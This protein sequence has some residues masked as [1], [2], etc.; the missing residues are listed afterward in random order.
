MIKNKFLVILSLIFIAFLG[1]FMSLNSK[2]DI[3]R[4]KSFIL[5]DNADFVSGGAISV[6]EN[7][8]VVTGSAIEIIPIDKDISDKYLKPFVTR[9]KERSYMNNYS[10][11]SHNHCADCYNGDLHVHDGESC[12]YEVR[13]KI[14]LGLAGNKIYRSNNAIDWTLVLSRNVS[15]LTYANER[16]IAVD[17]DGTS[18]GESFDGINWVFHSWTI[19][20]PPSKA[21][22]PYITSILYDRNG[23]YYALGSYTECNSEWDHPTRGSILV[24]TDLTNWVQLATNT[25]RG[26]SLGI[27]N[28]G[29]NGVNRLVFDIYGDADYNRPHAVVLSE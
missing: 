24:S 29:N 20:N 15:H 11:L 4:A 18:I 9:K 16:F 13:E 21:R 28:K 22:Y 7:A 6:K 5:E 23:Y 25:A 26:S 14:I 10:E 1:L 17:G 19:V 8:T 2:F 27:T 3:A 12:E